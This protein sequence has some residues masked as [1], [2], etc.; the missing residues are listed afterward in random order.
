VIALN[1][2]TVEGAVSLDAELERIYEE[3]RGPVCSYLLYLG[4]PVDQA[5]E[6]TQ[7]VFLRLHQAMRQGTPI[8]NLRAWLFRVAHN[9]G[10]RVRKKERSFRSITPDWDRLL[11]PSNSAE[12][13]LLERERNRRVSGAMETLSPQQRNCLYLR[14]E[15][16]RY[17]EI[18]EVI[19]VSP[20]TVN[21]FLRRAIAKLS[22]VANG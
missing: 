11:Q 1:D 13:M 21:E 18:A 7:E 12:D 8:E 5:Q 14:S 3:T 10:L 22:E 15:G 17:R 16:L 4:V 19:G 2:K 6:V 9:Q 20:S